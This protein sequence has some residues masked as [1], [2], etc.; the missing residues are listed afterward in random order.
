MA[1]PALKRLAPWQS[2]AGKT[3]R[4]A[5][6][7]GLAYSV[8]TGLSICNLMCRKGAAA[9]LAAAFK[10]SF[11]TDL[12]GRG[13]ANVSGEIR[14]A[15]DGPG[16]WRI[17]ADGETDG[18]LANR[19]KEMAGDTASIVDQ[20]HG[21]CVVRVSGERARDLLAKGTSLDVHPAAF[22]SGDCA[23][24]QIAHI[25]LHL[26]QI[27]DLPGYELQLFRSM[28]GSFERWLVDSGSQYGI[29]VG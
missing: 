18:H 25:S 19:L 21:L 9:E 5:A 10:T 6:G 24:T 26:T 12:P 27:N 1:S 14:S 16:R 17:I 20:S 4:G 15:W 29:D 2:L 13:K 22:G 7:S 11:G 8:V 23:M 3:H 28:A